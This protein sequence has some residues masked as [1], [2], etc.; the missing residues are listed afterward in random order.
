ML[1]NSISKADRPLPELLV[2][3]ADPGKLQT[4]LLYGADAIYLGGEGL[5]LRAKAGGFSFPALRQAVGMA[6]AHAVKVYF[7]LNLVAWEEQLAEIAR[8]LDELA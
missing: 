5:N 6:H 2:P 3:A 4:A 1:V 8:Y 7:T